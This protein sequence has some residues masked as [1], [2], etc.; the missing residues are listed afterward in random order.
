MN[1]FRGVFRG[2][3]AA[4]PKPVKVRLGV[5]SL[6]GVVV[7]V[8]VALV[9]AGCA[10]RRNVELLGH[11]S[12]TLLVADSKHMLF[13]PGWSPAGDRLI[14]DADV[15]CPFGNCLFGTFIVEVGTGDLSPLLKPY[16]VSGGAWTSESDIVSF[17]DYDEAGYGI[18]TVN[19]SS[20]ERRFIV[21]G[22]QASW[23]PDGRYIA[24]ARQTS[25]LPGSRALYSVFVSDLHSG[26]EQIVFGLPSAAESSITGLAWSRDSNWLALS[27]HWLTLPE[28]IWTSSMF[29][30][31]VDGSELKHVTD[32][33]WEP[34]WL[35]DSK[36]LYFVTND[37][38][39]AFAP[40]MLDCIITPLDIENIRY[41]AISPSGDEIAFTHN[42]NLYLL[43]L[44]ELLGPN[45]EALA[46]PG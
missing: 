2:L 20:G 14:V 25:L 7:A 9:A 1:T 39:L 45:R 15:A 6:A 46:C 23:S 11:S 35:P 32:G 22:G 26:R 28:W 10:P 12:V 8:L 42:R 43:D 37:W 34:G 36:W 29:V 31:K 24:F 30:V 44:D 17:I 41:P 18:H 27:V 13:E 40:L 16:S 33:A 3:L 5:G 38:R 21:D 4:R 19:L